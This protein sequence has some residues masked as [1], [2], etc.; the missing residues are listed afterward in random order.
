MP[1]N[2]YAMNARNSIR[3]VRWHELRA[4]KHPKHTLPYVRQVDSSQ[5]KVVTRNY[6]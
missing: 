1:A 2:G 5:Q 6:Q 3:G 4:D